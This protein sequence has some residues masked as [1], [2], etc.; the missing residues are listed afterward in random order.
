MKRWIIAALAAISLAAGEEEAKIEGWKVLDG[1]WTKRGDAIATEGGHLQYDGEVGDSITIKCEIKVSKWYDTRKCNMAVLWAV[2]PEEGNYNK[3]CDVVIW[4]DKIS[5][6]LRTD[7]P[8][9][10]NIKN[11][12][13]VVKE[14]QKIPVSIKLT[15]NRAQ[16]KVGKFTIA[17]PCKVSKIGPVM[18][19]AWQA[20]GEFSKLKI[21]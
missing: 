8:S 1:S 15:R 7:S 13:L 19:H 17:E 20:A 18:L 3:R 2:E 5:C 21:E 12:P 11:M 10:F 16:I 9:G 6:K 14:G 4:P